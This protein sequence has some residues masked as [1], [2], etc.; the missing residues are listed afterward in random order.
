M[1]IFESLDALLT[2]ARD[3]VVAR[4]Q[5]ALRARRR[6]TLALSGGS[7]PKRLYES[8]VGAEI[9]WART[10]VFFG[11]ERCVP[12]DHADSNYRMAREALLSKV[13]I[14]EKN[15][16]RVRSEDADPERAAKAYEQDLQSFFKLRPGELPVFDLCLMGMG[17]DGHTA[18]LFPGTSALA[19]E[20]RLAV[21]P[22]VEKLNSWRVTLTAPVF[23]HARSVLFLVAGE[24]KAQALQG[25]LESERP[26]A[27]LPSKLIKPTAGELLWWVDKAAAKLLA[28]R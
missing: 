11:D 21:A 10:Q 13:A 1:R 2:A 15:V 14:P 5:K 23:N 9:D 8:L 4:A 6:F 25:V 18:S 28:G 24:D 17:P 3:E 12:P 19:E 27:E 7:T 22:F 20:V 16:H 26:A